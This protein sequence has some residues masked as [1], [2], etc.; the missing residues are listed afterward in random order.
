MLNL[1]KNLFG[2]GLIITFADDKATMSNRRDKNKPTLNRQ[3]EQL[4]EMNAEKE[5]NENQI[6]LGKFFY[7]IAG[8]TYAG[9]VL[10]YVMEHHVIDVDTL[11]KGV[12]ATILWA[13]IGWI[14]VKAGNIKR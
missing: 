8:M 7:S 14:F 12:V 4:V 10:S 5:K 1:L 2:I 11:M 13:L 9:A 3:L 6:Q